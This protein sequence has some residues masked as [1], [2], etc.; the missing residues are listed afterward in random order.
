[1]E[2][3]HEGKPKSGYL[4]VSV[5]QETTSLASKIS[6]DPSSSLVQ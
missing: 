6:R 4:L 3:W 2:A 5:E 1:M